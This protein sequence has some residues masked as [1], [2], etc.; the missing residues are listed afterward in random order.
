MFNKNTPALRLFNGE[1][2][3]TKEELQSVKRDIA[4]A[5]VIFEEDRE[6]YTPESVVGAHEQL[7]ILL[8]LANGLLNDPVN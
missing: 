5:F 7:S 8:E 3:L 6:K 4:A 2:N 1:T